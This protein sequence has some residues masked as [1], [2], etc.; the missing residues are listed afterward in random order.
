MPPPK[1]PLSIDTRRIT[2]F[3]GTKITYRATR[4]RDR[5]SDNDAGAPVVVLANGLGGPYLAWRAQIDALSSRC[6]VLTWD[7]RGLYASGRPPSGSAVE[8]Y[9]VA[10]HVR[11]LQAI[12]REEGIERASLVGWSMGVQVVL[13]AFRMLPGLAQNLVLLCGS[14]G[15]PLDTLSPLPGAKSVLPSLVGAATRAHELA[16]QMARRGAAQPEALSWLK[17]MGLIG[18]ALDDDVF[19]ELVHSFGEL[20]MQAYLWNLRALGEHDAE[21]VLESINVPSLVIAGER[22]A[23][24]PITLARKMAR[25]IPDA[26]LALVRGGTHYTAVEFPELV[27]LR[28]ERFYRKHGFFKG[29]ERR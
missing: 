4:A 1:P 22:D 10:H 9:H 7:Y 3:D 19:A 8:A 16:T 23:F 2:S 13:E 27:N 17:R 29:A 6:R 21:D 15:R 12:L 14:Y 11:D 18:R 25:R 28:I 20:D 5:D 24:M 26:E